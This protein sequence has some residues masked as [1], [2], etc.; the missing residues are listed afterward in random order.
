MTL[1]PGREAVIA[2]SAVAPVLADSAVRSEQVTQ[3]VLGE[4]AALLDRRGEWIRVRTDADG[5][6]GWVNEGYVRVVSSEERAAWRG[7]ACGWSEGARV[8]VGGEVVVLPLRARVALEDG[9][10]SLPDGRAGRCIDGE[11]RAA[12][13]VAAAARRLPAERW[14]LERFRGAPYQWGG[15]TPWGVDCSGLVQTTF[16]ARGV[17]VPRDSAQQAEAGAAVPLDAVRPGDLLFF[18]SER[19]PGITH[20]AFAAEGDTLIHSTIARGG[21]VQEPF[22]PD[23]RAGDALRPRLVAARRIPER[24]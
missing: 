3:L 4:T 10:V 16:A 21:V 11:V 1:G 15:L 2:T 8:A 17:E 6:E 12:A 13:D 24:P 18:H 23:S 22:T 19:G 9:L 14:A 5:Y 7:Q 20:V